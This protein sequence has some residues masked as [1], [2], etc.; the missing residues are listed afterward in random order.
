MFTSSDMS[1][2]MDLPISWYRP[3]FPWGPSNMNMNLVGTGT[4]VRSPVRKNIIVKPDYDQVW[5]EWIATCKLPHLPK[6]CQAFLHWTNF[7][8]DQQS[9]TCVFPIDFIRAFKNKWLNSTRFDASF[10][11]DLVASK[12][13]IITNFLV[14]L[15]CSLFMDLLTDPCMNPMEIEQSINTHLASVP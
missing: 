14:L 8:L 3:W 13:E 7:I 2:A 15:E 5:C 4:S 12:A 1:V 6:V 10:F 11:W 9:S